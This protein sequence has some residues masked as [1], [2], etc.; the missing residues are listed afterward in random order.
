MRDNPMLGLLAARRRRS[1]C[2]QS[3]K[4]SPLQILMALLVLFPVGGIL[5]ACTVGIYMEEGPFAAGS[6]VLAV[7]AV[8]GL[9]LLPAIAARTGGETLDWLNRG[10]CIEEMLNSRLR[11][12]Q[13]VDGVTLH[14]AANV[15]KMAVPVWL[16]LLLVGAWLYT[17]QPGLLEGWA[18]V[19]VGWLL[20]VL[21]FSVVAAYVGQASGWGAAGA[22][23]H[24]GF[25]VTLWLGPGLAAGLIGFCILLDPF[26]TGAGYAWMGLG[27][28]LTGASARQ[29]TIKQLRGGGQQ[30]RLQRFFASWW[31]RARRQP[32][33][34]EHPNPVVVRELMRDNSRVWL[35]RNWGSLAVYALAMLYAIPFWFL[36]GKD[37]A[38]WTGAIVVGVLVGVLANVAPLRAAMRSMDIV[39]RDREGRTV[40]TLLLSRITLREMVEGAA[41][42]GW[43]PRVREMIVLGTA[44]LVLA[45][46]GLAVSPMTQADMPE[47][48]PMIA[49][50]AVVGAG[51]VVV[52]TLT[53]G[54]IGIVAASGA[55]NRQDAWGRM[56]A[57]GL[58]AGFAWQMGHAVLSV[59]A[60]FG[61]MAAIVLTVGWSLLFPLVLLLVSRRYAYL[62][63]THKPEQAGF[64]TR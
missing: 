2:R 3:R 31:L 5:T 57:M 15:L 7:L 58:G 38:E 39:M 36:M 24:R 29:L 43:W 41:W 17:E 53:G 4:V 34:V 37:T 16:G 32:A 27:L 52:C 9:V 25:V 63:L 33:R 13:I 6:C 30:S 28:L 49:L 62:G 40:E 59:G 45:L 48:L 11:P 19:G 22:D 64:G 35:A 20:A 44:L 23:F 14:A 21:V 10:R 1:S 47:F 26:S 42:L 12:A 8:A 51:Y 50:I 60:A 55:K 54:Y 18:A 46:W 56:I 61:Y